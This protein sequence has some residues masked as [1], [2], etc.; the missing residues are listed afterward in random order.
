MPSINLRSLPKEG[1]TTVEVVAGLPTKKAELF[2]SA[3]ICAADD[4][5][6]RAVKI[7]ITSTPMPVRARLARCHALSIRVSRR[8]ILAGAQLGRPELVNLPLVDLESPGSRTPLTKE[9]SIAAHFSD[10][11]A[12][13]VKSVT[14]KSER[15]RTKRRTWPKPLGE[16]ITEIT[17]GAK[18]NITISSSSKADMGH[19]PDTFRPAETL[20]SKVLQ[21]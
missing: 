16:S 12:H 1:A 19:T 5:A 8:V 7:A 17:F 9:P 20:L 13:L 14:R 6:A 3:R 18:R 15:Q 2:C 21:D 10:S 4:D 11:S